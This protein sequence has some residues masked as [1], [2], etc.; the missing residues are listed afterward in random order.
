MFADV[1]Q[2]QGSKQRI[3]DGVYQHIAI[4]VGYTPLVVGY[5]HATQHKAQTIAQGVNII[6]VT[7][8]EHSDTVFYRSLINHC[9]LLELVA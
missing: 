5:L 9:R 8:S 6:S 3:A 1:A 7:Y 4:G 2:S